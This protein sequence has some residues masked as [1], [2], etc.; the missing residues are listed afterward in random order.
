MIEKIKKMNTVLI[1]LILISIVVISTLGRFVYVEIRDSF[2]VTQ[3]FFFQS[4]KLTESHAHY[5]INDYNG[6]DS[7]DIIINLNTLDNNMLKTT[8]DVDYDVTY[9]CSSN[10]NCS[11]SKSE[12]TIYSSNST[13]YFIATV[14][15]NVTLQD[16]DTISIEV[17]VKSTSPYEKEL[18]AEFVLQV[19]HYGLSHRIDDGVGDPYLELSVTNTLDY[20]TVLEP[21]ES[22]DIYDTID[23]QTYLGLSEENKQK[24]ASS[25]V[26]FS[27]DPN[28][29]RL[30]MTSDIYIE[31]LRIETETIDGHEYINFISFKI[32]AISSVR[33]KFYK[34]DDQNDHTYPFVNEDSI[35]EVTYSLNDQVTEPTVPTSGMVL[36]LDSYAI[37]GLSDGDPINDWPD[38]SSH[39]ND[40]FQTIG[41]RVPTYKMEDKPFVRFNEDYFETS[42]N[43]EVNNFHAVSSNFWSLSLVFRHTGEDGIIAGAAGGIGG[44]TTFAIYMQNNDVRVRLRGNTNGALQTVGSNIPQGTWHHILVTWDGSV[45][46]GYLNGGS[47]VTLPVG[48]SGNQGENYY[49]GSSRNNLANYPYFTGDVAENIVYNSVLSTEERNQLEQYISGKWLD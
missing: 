23:I 18:S 13:D 8:T 21:F 48:T 35:V 6:V 45:A 17:A 2:F 47:S 12:G 24:C 4:D 49:I 3:N 9:S 42:L 15:P 16:Q 7:Y 40:A 10:A 34:V 39:E 30:N 28:V 33:T 27:F 14:A 19:G 36:H 31:S 1:F 25:I 22:Y 20:Y 32:D 46:R 41:G 5:Q 29:L 11:V 37:S 44:A 38:L 26:E 43:T